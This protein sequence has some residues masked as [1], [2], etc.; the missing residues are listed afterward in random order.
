MDHAAGASVIVQLAEQRGE[1]AGGD[2]G[3]GHHPGDHFIAFARRAALATGTAEVLASLARTTF[4]TPLFILITAKPY[5]S[6]TLRK[7]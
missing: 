1:I 3:Q 2:V 7:N 4:S 5:T 6:S